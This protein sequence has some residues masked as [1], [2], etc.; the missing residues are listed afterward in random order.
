MPC[1]DHIPD[2]PLQTDAFIL[3]RPFIRSKNGSL[4]TEDYPKVI[5]E[6]VDEVV[7]KTIQQVRGV[8]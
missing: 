5:E 2:K 6:R 1:P 4:V 3:N 7:R 8:V